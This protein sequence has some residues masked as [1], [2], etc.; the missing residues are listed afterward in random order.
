MVSPGN[1]RLYT[2]VKIPLVMETL[3]HMRPYLTEENM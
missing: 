2:P 1:F 3:P